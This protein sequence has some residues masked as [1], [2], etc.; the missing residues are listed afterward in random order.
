MNAQATIK[1]LRETL[2]FKISKKIIEKISNEFELL[3]NSE[4]LTFSLRFNGIE[5]LSAE[6]IPEIPEEGSIS[7][8]PGNKINNSNNCNKNK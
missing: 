7:F 3:A 4:D 2:R 5:A 8:L 1:F 6:Y